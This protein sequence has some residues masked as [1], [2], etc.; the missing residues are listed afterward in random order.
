[1]AKSRPSPRPGPPAERPR[2]RGARPVAELVGQ[3]GGVAFRRFG[4]VQASVVTRWPEIVGERYARA[5]VPESI[6]FPRG[7]RDGGT[8]HLVAH[9]AH[10]PMLQHV[11]PQITERVNRFFGYA[12]VQKL[13]IRQGA[14][15]A[16]RSPPRPAVEA[17]LAP[18]PET[19]GLSLRA[20]ADP[21]LR[22]VLT[23]LARGVATPRPTPAPILRVP[24]R[25]RVS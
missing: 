11:A 2:G 13:A 9:G 24:I 20:V 6:R 1:M 12:A 15:P 19:L 17:E 23:A 8:L 25:G 16:D 10:A 7:K 14:M 3:V 21:E 18:V 22:E 4:F 5:C